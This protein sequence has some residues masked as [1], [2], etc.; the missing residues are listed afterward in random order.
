[1]L[2]ESKQKI[3]M[4]LKQLETDA[5][6]DKRPKRTG[7]DLKKFEDGCKKQPIEEKSRL[8]YAW[9]RKMLEVWQ[10]DF[11]QA[12]PDNFLKTPEGKIELGILQ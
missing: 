8:V 3:E 1:L 9:C 7:L 10:K 11:E 12:R 2:E 5:T 4:A 6:N